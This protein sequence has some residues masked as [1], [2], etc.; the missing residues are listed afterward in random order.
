M[1]AKSCEG[2]WIE[3]TEAK[4]VEVFLEVVTSLGMLEIMSL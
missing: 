4:S 3:T 2:L 1:L